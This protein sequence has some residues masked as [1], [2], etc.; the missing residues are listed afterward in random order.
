MALRRID[1]GTIDATTGEAPANARRRREGRGWGPFSGGQLTV[2]VVT[3]AVLLLFPVGAWALSFS[4]VAITD[5]GGV[6]QAKVDAGKNLHAA[7]ADP[8]G[9]NVAK[10]D[11]K[12]NLNTAIHDAG[13]GTAAKVN[14]FGQLSAAVTG[15]V[16]ANVAYPTSAIVHS[17]DGAGNPV[18]GAS[19]DCSSGCA[20]VIAPPAGK[21]LVVTSIHVDTYMDSIPGSGFFDFVRSSDGSCSSASI[22]IEMEEVNPPGI[23]MTDLQYDIPGG[24]TIPA[25][26][27]LCVWSADPA[28]LR[29]AVTAWGYA[30]A[31][32]AV[33]AFAPAPGAPTGA[34][35]LTP[36]Q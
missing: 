29:A 26:K 23:G 32:T 33:P 25:G 28:H 19:A 12:N 6:N 30:V 34:A 15:A 4:N 22:D 8:G 24:M 5:P 21:A 9:V 20:K 3:F 35:L 10:V 1:R 13:T 31:S 27:A 7:V 2:I 11:A 36:H 14:G 17:D 18:V 16:T